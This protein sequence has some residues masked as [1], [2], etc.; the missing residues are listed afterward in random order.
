MPTVIFDFDSTLISCESL[1]ELQGRHY[2]D[3]P[4]RLQAIHD[5]TNQGMSGDIPFSEAIKK[6]L[7]LLPP[8]LSDVMSF[9]EK[10][11]EY[12]TPGIDTLIRELHAKGVEVWLISGGL[13]E[14]LLAVGAKLQIPADRIRAVQL[15]WNKDG[16]FDSLDP[17]DP[18]S[19][20]KY[21]GA[22][23]CASLWSTPRIMVGDGMTDYDVYAQ[24]LSDHF[25][26]F[27]Q[28][29]S[30]T[31]VLN[32]GCPEAPDIQSLSSMIKDLLSR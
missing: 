24:G 19:V 31:A 7:D 28:H 6:R 21:D 13:L 23:T 32:K 4:E 25:I 12:L 3:Q 22:K 11:H 27:T 17:N 10:A 16:S 15:L 8:T 2:L 5:L 14:V 30:R 20:S 26:A 29:V 9:A 1:E 18:F